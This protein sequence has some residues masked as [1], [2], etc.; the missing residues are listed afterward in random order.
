MSGVLAGD[1]VVQGSPVTVVLSDQSQ[2]VMP[3]VTHLTPADAVVELKRVGWTADL[4]TLTRKSQEVRDEAQGGTISSQTLPVGTHVGIAA[5]P[6]VTIGT[7]PTFTMPN[8]QGLTLQAAKDQ[9][10]GTGWQGVENATQVP[11]T[12]KDVTLNGI[13]TGFNPPVGTRVKITDSIDISNYGTYPPPTDPLSHRPDRWSDPTARYGTDPIQDR[14]PVFRSL[15]AT[16]HHQG[17]RLDHVSY[18]AGPDG[19]DATSERLAGQLGAA[20]MDG[21]VHPRFGTRNRILPLTDRHYLEV[22]EAL[23]HPAVDQ[24]PFGQAV[25][26]RSES[27]GG[28]LGWVVSVDN[29]A[30]VEQRLG[31]P[32]T[33]A[34]RVLPDGFDLTWDQIGVSGLMNDPQ[35]PFF[36]HWTSAADHHPSNDAHTGIGL[37]SL[38]IA[39]DPG[40]VTEWLGEPVDHPLDDVD[41]Q[42]SSPNGQPGL[43][44]VTFSSPLGDVT[45]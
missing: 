23:D 27:G 28:W 26:A 18:A 45:V 29:I 35:L 17:M 13:V 15:C 22:V 2:F 24:L 38:A 9:L 14:D 12:A 21:G 37:K 7:E 19:L 32:S 44:S 41:V 1:K 43:L 30:K 33:P 4:S 8:V 36:V 42:W 3:D 40:R 25:R 31:R 11:N 5:K 6:V 10:R 39:G 34:H 20:P 16:C